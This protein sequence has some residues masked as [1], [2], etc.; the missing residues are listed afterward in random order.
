M[1]EKP[2]DTYRYEREERHRAYLNTGLLR[3]EFPRIEQLT[4]QLVFTDASG[5]SSYSSQMR[6]F[7]P[8]AIAF[9]E[10]P[11][12]SA[13]CMG[14][15]FNLGSVIWKL[16]GRAG[17]ETAG[18]LDCQGR[19]STDER[20]PHYCPVQLHYRVTVAYADPLEPA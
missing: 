13:A 12:P 20:D 15:G 10:I 5:M 3:D 8:A 16:S 6:S 7:A 14:G 2:L 17:H 18:R 4:L 9:F 11:C 1:S 19:D